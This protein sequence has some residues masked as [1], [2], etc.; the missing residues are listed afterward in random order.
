[1]E[2]NRII[3]ETF[4]KVKDPIE[5]GKIKVTFELDIN[6]LLNVTALEVNTKEVVHAQFQSSTGQTVKDSQVAEMTVISSVNATENTLIKRATAMLAREDVEQEDK[7]DLQVLVDTY[8][9][10]ES[11]GNT[12]A[13]SKI[14]EDILDLLYYLEKEEV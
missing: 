13:L 10:E 11:E 4:L 14:E 1:L 6:G 12:A 2:D 7:V 9:Q 3:G 5:E 8:Q